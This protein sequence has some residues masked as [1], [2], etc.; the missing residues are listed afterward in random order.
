MR[1]YCRSVSSSVHLPRP[2]RLRALK[3]TA[4]V[5]LAI[6]S[7]KV[8]ADINFGGEA[9]AKYEYNSNIFDLPAGY[10]EAG[11]PVSKRDDWYQAYGGTLQAN[12]LWDQ[13]KFYATLTGKEFL[14]DYFTALNHT[15]YS[16]DGG[17]AW[18]AG[19][20]LD[21]KF[22]VTRSHSMVPF[23]NL[24]QTQISVTTDQKETAQIGWQFIPDWRVQGVGYY[25]T[26]EQPLV[27]SPDLKLAETSGQ[28]AL[29]YLGRAG[30]VAGISGTYTRG[31]YTGSNTIANPDYDQET[32]Q[33]IATYQVTGSSSFVGQA[34]YSRR[35]STSLF[36]DT[37]GPTGRFVYKNQLTP[38]T[39]V[40]VSIERDINSYIT[41]SGSEFDTSAATGVTWQATYK[42][43]VTANYV[44]TRSLLPDQGNTPDTNR[45]D[46][47]QF[48]NLKIDYQ[49]LRWLWVQPYANVQTRS[50]N[51]IGAA[52]NSSVYGV[53]FNVL[54]HCPT[55]RC[56]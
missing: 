34:G 9:T 52:F 35:T 56:T 15:E 19:T 50:S 22:D 42:L 6:S 26:D 43:S 45:I 12:D 30:L 38:K 5:V 17:L 53:S 55:E 1:K 29:Q 48:V 27:G 18:K 54:W 3:G 20:D 41:N 49:P 40:N 14:Y 8:S 37:S 16:F 7:A 24:L 23:T 47:L 32:L 13:N 39:S 28:L 25:H 21:G 2:R 46:H 36:D 4:I 33:F 51:F 31:N 11:A 44:Y 10:T